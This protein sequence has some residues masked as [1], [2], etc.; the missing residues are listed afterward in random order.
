MTVCEFSAPIIPIRM[1]FNLLSGSAIMAEAKEDEEIETAD[2]AAPVPIVFIKDLLER[3][4]V[5]ILLYVN[6]LI[7]L[8]F[9]RAGNT[10]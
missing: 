9:K 3:I 4:I 8:F 5:S 2:K 1:G 7:L 6:A 10:D